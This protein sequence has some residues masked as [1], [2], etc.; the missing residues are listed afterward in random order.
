MCHSNNSSSSSNSNRISNHQRQLLQQLQPL[1]QHSQNHTEVVAIKFGSR[2]VILSRNHRA[3]SK[4]PINNRIINPNTIQHR[5]AASRRRTRA[6]ALPMSRK[7][8]TTRAGVGVV[9]I[10]ITPSSTATIIPGVLPTTRSTSKLRNPAIRQCRAMVIIPI[11]IHAI[12][13]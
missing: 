6:T 1:V 12:L 2:K 7:T 11:R 8:A 9:C 13:V 10:I 4:I 3:A 5:T